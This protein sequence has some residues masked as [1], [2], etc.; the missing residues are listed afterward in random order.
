MRYENVNIYYV[1]YF[2]SL[3]FDPVFCVILL[4]AKL[5]FHCLGS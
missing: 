5:E 3:L 1:N 2:Y 4:N